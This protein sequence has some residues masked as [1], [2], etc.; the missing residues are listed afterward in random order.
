MFMEDVSLHTIVILGKWNKMLL[1]QMFISC[2]NLF[3]AYTS[4]LL[5]LKIDEVLLNIR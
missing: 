1:G 3:T 5:L 4:K 2:I